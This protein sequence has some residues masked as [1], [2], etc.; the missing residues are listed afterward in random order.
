MIDLSISLALQNSWIFYLNI[1]YG[2]I[3]IGTRNIKIGKIPAKLAFKMWI[4]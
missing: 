3:N 2:K 1:Y 4:I